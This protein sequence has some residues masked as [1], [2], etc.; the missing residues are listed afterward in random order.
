MREHGLKEVEMEKL[1]IFE[2]GSDLYVAW[3]FPDDDGP[4]AWI[5]QEKN[6]LETSMRKERATALEK[7][8]W[9]EFLYWSFELEAR[10]MLSEEPFK[11][12]VLTASSLGYLFNGSSSAAKKLKAALDKLTKK[13][14]VEFDSHDAALPEWANLALAA[15][16]ERPKGWKP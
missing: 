12:N 7:R 11:E 16:W 3:V 6:T 5:G 14:K 8:D 9:G 15:G 1:D 2:H 10:R 13:L 4:G